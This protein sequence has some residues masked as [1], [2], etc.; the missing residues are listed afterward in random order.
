MRGP[1]GLNYGIP[2]WLEDQN[3]GFEATIA[4]WERIATKLQPLAAIA[5]IDESVAQMAIGPA[6]QDCLQMLGDAG[7]RID[8][9]SFPAMMQSLAGLA[10]ATAKTRVV[11][12]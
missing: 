12:L 6:V 2:M 8:E 11:E 9:H 3:L 1:D 7:C 4:L 10:G 5:R